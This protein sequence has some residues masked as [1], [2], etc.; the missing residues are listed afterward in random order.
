MEREIADE[1]KVPVGIVSYTE[2]GGKSDRNRF[3]R[4]KAT[5]ESDKS[6]MTNFCDSVRKHFL[7]NV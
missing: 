7:N 2:N 6:P 3:G 4:P 5:A 1:A